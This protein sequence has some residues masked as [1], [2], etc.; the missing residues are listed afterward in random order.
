VLLTNSVPNV[1]TGTTS[2]SGKSMR[3]LGNEH[4]LRVPDQK[5]STLTAGTNY[6]AVIS[7]GQD[8][9]SANTLGTNSSSFSITS[10]GEL[11]VLDLGQMGETQIVHSSSIEG[12][13]VQ[14]Y[15]VSVPEDFSSIEARLET[16]EGNPAMVVR[17]GTELPDPGAASVKSGLGSVSKEIYGSEGG[18]GLAAGLGEA[19]SQLITLPVSTNRVY[20]ILV[21]ARS[22]SG[23]FTN[24]T[25]TLRLRA[26]NA[27]QLDF[28]GGTVSVTDQ[29]P[30]SWRYF[31]VTVPPE[32]EGWDIRLTDVAAGLPRLV[33]SR[34]ELPVSLTT[35]T[36]SRPGSSSNWPS[37]NQ[38]AAGPD[39]TRRATST[40][41]SINEDGRILAMGAGRP[42]EPGTYYIGVV[43]NAT[44]SPMSYTLLSRGIG[45]GLAVSIVDLS[46][47]GGSAL[48]TDLPAREAAYFR[49]EV[50]TNAPSWKLRLAGLTGEALLIATK[51]TLP[52]VD[53]GRSGVPGKLMQKAGREHYVMLPS[54]G[55]T[56]IASGTYY[57]AVVSEGLNPPST[58]RI[59]TGSTQF[60]VVSEGPLSIVPLGIASPVAIN[61]GD[62]LEGGEVKAYQ[63]GVR[64]GAAAIELRLD[65]RVGNPVMVVAGKSQLPDPG[66]NVQGTQD[67][68]GNDGGVVIETGNATALTLANPTNAV[69]TLL[70]KARPIGGA[71]LDASYLLRLREL[72]APTLNFSSSENTN[73]L[74]HSVSRT[75]E[76][77]QRAFFKV[78]V[79]EYNA[80]NTPVIGWELTLAQASGMAFVR[81]R[82]DLPPSDLHTTGMAFTPA[83]AILVSPFLTHG[84][85]YVEVRGSNT[86]SF[87]LTSRSLALRRPVW[88]MPAA[89]ELPVT[90][91]LSAPEFGDTG[92]DVN[93]TELPETDRGTDL[94]QGYS[95]Y[96]AVD[97]PQ[98]NLGLMRVQLDAISGNPDLYARLAVPPTASHRAD[99]RGGS[100]LDRGLFG[101]TTEYANW[102]PF[103]GRDDVEL[104]AGRYYLAV[105]AL[106][107]ANARYRL[108]L[109]TGAV[110]DL[111]LL[112][113]SKQGQVL[114]GGDWRYYRVQI[115]ADAPTNWNVTFTQQSGD[116][117]LYLR[118]TVPPGHGSSNVLSQIKDWKT[119]NKDGGAYPNFPTPG[120][121]TLTVPPVRPGH[122]Y[123]L[124]FR[125]NNDSMFSVS[126]SAGADLFPLWPVIEFYGG[127]VT[128]TIAPGGEVLYRVLTPADAARWR[129]FATHANTVKL[130]IKNGFPPA[131]N[132]TDNWRSTQANSTF[133]QFLGGWPWLPD[134]TYYLV[135]TN[136]TDA[137]Q[138]FSFLLE[139]RSVA[140]DDDDNDGMLDA[141]EMQYFRNT[142][143]TPDGDFDGDGISNLTEYLEGTNPA[144][145]KSLNPRLTV[146]ATNGIVRINPAL[147]QYLYRATVILEAVAEPGYE[148]TQ[149]SGDGAGTANPLALIMDG[150]KTVVANFRVPG[151]DFIQR[152][153]L[154]GLAGTAVASN[155]GATI[156]PGEPDHSTEP[157]GASIWWT[158]LAPFSG[159]TVINVRGDEFD[160]ILAVYTGDT[161]EQ[162]ARV[163]SDI[164]SAGP[165]ISEVQFVAEAGTWYHVAVAGWTGAEGEL[166]LSHSMPG[167]IALDIP[168]Q[169][170]NQAV[171]LTLLSNPGTTCRI[172]VSADLIHWTTLT[173]VVNPTGYMEV[174]DPD[175]A[176]HP[177]RFYRAVQP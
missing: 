19:N 48:V 136:T 74:T 171:R 133:N 2:G 39:W 169:T 149:W 103:N 52:N 45:P 106:G 83:A 12:G 20:T 135:A 168:V 105:R 138:P 141:W 34:D 26:I 60:Q 139:G 137:P 122:T 41:G 93:G 175:A 66:A 134:Q 81:A 68:Y 155:I 167:L 152:V 91:G 162:L 86:T 87:T 30:N 65:D 129:H 166:V 102:V 99:G 153:N 27:R 51:D 131:R 128:N 170:S 121:H 76:D 25:Y 159:S 125:A 154:P 150:N 31:V 21:K 92:V 96:Y 14:A 44:S 127:Y 173:N 46:F 94:N 9:A 13:Q 101:T 80:D 10:V 177:I 98:G 57:L 142:S 29:A 116:V 22:V 176:D 97:V 58:T 156:E 119:D 174:D 132:S 1:L 35:R 59:G 89:G 32:A 79:P 143:Q 42:L 50:P 4:Y 88:Q 114:A 6:L 110:E 3:K 49:V 56:N 107:N 147:S 63:F 160:T 118:D 112:G 70:I 78:E 111:D 140:V 130:Y 71:Y 85:W 17:A 47:A 151:D 158:W 145:A 54:A 11:A 8:P 144:D 23:N 43:N 28:D 61:R 16:I 104:P 117:V 148:F 72:E 24:A 18:Y 7:E 120:V 5:Q 95:H 165:G 157:S 40:S 75:L 73:G 123:Y 84:T 108:R 77:N 55:E 36:W 113:G 69:Y 82:K 33:V 38:W 164:N 90:P 67:L 126:S 62:A 163:A 100:L 115:P 64:P 37:G 15:R 161:V 109:S 53:S 172:E 124:G 146:Q